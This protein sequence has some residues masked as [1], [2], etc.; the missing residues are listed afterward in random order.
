MVVVPTVPLKDHASNPVID[1]S[2]TL[3]HSQEMMVMLFADSA[4]RWL[5]EGLSELGRDM[6][7]IIS[8]LLL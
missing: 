2:K 7:F 3:S 5:C 1:S 6:G 8:A 4:S